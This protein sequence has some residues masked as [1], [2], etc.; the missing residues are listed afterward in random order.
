MLFI[1]SCNE[2][3]TTDDNLS[4]STDPVDEL[5]PN[6]DYVIFDSGGRRNNA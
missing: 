5:L 4:H 1:L 6:I 3:K 2:S